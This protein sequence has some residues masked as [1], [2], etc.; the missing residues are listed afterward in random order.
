M[1]NKIVFAGVLIIGLIAAGCES[2]GTK[3]RTGALTGGVIGAGTGGI[4]GHQM[5]RGIEGAV[6]GAA[7]G[8]LSGGLIGNQLDKLDQMGRANNPQYLSLISIAEMGKK[9]VP[10]SV[11]IDEIQRTNSRYNLTSE[12]INYLKENKIGDKV[13]DYMLSTAY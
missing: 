12:V 6:I 8:A 7:V 5:G 10:D 13:I 2:M 4:I 11:I 9:G 3:S 1:K